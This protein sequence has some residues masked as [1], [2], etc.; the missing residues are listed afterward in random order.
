MLSYV[1]EVVIVD[2]RSQGHTA[3][4]VR[5]LRVDVV[6]SVL[7][8]LASTSAG[9]VRARRLAHDFSIQLSRTASQGAP[10]REVQ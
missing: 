9:Y 6:G 2:V 3:D 5:A 4:V 8:V 7:A 10:W 1:D